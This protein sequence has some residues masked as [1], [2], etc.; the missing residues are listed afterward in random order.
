M[1]LKEDKEI[2][3]EKA[4]YIM[5]FQRHRIV[6]DDGGVIGAGI[7]RENIIG[8]GIITG[9]GNDFDQHY[10]RFVPRGENILEV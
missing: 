10:L 8:T 3:K 6:H 7:R 4:Y 9:Y 2:L 5:C 1:R